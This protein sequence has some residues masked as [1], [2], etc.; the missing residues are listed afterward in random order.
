MK[1]LKKIL[2]SR[3]VIGYLFVLPSLFFLGMFVFLPLLFAFVSSFFDFNLVLS[4]FRFV[5]TDNFHNVLSDERFWNSMK[6]TLFFTVIIV[7]VQNCLSLLTAAAISRQSKL[8]VLFRTVYFLPVVCSMTIVAMSLKIMFD[9]NIGI[10][11]ALARRVGFPVVDLLNDP[12][13]AMPTII[14]ISV[15]KSFGFN[16][17]IFIAA[18]QSVPAMLYE[19]ADMDGASRTAKFFRITIPCILPTVFFTLIT[20]L[21][22]SFQVFDQVYVTTK[23]GPLFR[24]ETIVQLIYERAFKTHEMG[25]ANAAAVLLF[26]VILAATLVNW[27]FSRSS[28]KEYQGG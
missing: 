7:P 1:Q 27:K 13:W 16:M 6:N 3:S 21:I 14:L 9:F 15:Y 20:S 10:L 24:T 19:A 12:T 11:P 5:G 26:L 18:I 8:N 17:V 4:D 28:E 25:F 23:G 2:Y 22:S